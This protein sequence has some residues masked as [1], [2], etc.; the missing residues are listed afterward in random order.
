MPPIV[1]DDTPR[2]MPYARYAAGDDAYAAYLRLRF[3][4]QDIASPR[5]TSAVIYAAHF[6][7]RQY[8][9]RAA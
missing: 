2:L 7:F 1:R 8:F 6:R 9:S 4:S 3:S 5:A